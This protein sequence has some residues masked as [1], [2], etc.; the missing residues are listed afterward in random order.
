MAQRCL[1]PAAPCGSAY[2]GPPA[3]HARAREVVGAAESRGSP[4][5]SGVTA[6]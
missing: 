5:E 2:W 1:D 4:N 6:L 3:A